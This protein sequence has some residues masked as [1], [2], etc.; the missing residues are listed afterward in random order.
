MAFLVQFKTY[1][2]ICRFAAQR[3]YAPVSF[4]IDW[5]QLLRAT[6]SARDAARYARLCLLLC[7]NDNAPL[8]QIWWI[9]AE[10]GFSRAI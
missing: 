10:N 3:R 7:P 1:A 9:S 2:D 6:R 8:Y 4:G 5:K